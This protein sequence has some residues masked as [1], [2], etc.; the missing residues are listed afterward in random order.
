[1]LQSLKGV[2]YRVEGNS[3]RQDFWRSGVLVMTSH[4]LLS[5]FLSLKTILQKKRNPGT[6][7]N[8]VV[9]KKP[10]D[11]FSQILKLRKCIVMHFLQSG[12]AEWK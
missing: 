6:K 12:N 5:F 9:I 3:I 2:F 1:M 7:V 4:L 10:Q 8:A 11:W